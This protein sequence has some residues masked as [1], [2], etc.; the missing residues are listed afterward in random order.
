[1]LTLKRLQTAI[2]SA[3]PPLQRRSSTYHQF[4]CQSTAHLVVYPSLLPSRCTQILHYWRFHH[5]SPEPSALECRWHSG[6]FPTWLA[7]YTKTDWWPGV[8][9]HKIHGSDFRCN[10]LRCR[11]ANV[12][13][14]NPCNHHGAIVHCKPEDLIEASLSELRDAETWLCTTGF[15]REVF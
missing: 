8:G 10:H 3:S 4:S 15:H 5:P 9:S 13:K 2:S 1:M 11:R 6:P 14:R 12:R 7:M